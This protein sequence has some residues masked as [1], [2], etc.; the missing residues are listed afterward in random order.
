MKKILSAATASVLLFGAAGYSLAGTKY[1]PVKGPAAASQGCPG[2][3]QDQ[4]DSLNSSQARQDE[5]INGLNSSQ[6]RQ[7]EQINALQADQGRQD[8]QINALEA[9]QAQQDE[10]IRANSARLDQHDNEINALKSRKH[11]AEYNP[12]YVKGLARMIWSGSMDADKVEYGFKADT[13]TGY[14]LAL[15]GGRKIGNFRAEAELA[16]Q[17]TDFATKGLEDMSVRS[18]MF[19]GFYHVPVSTFGILVGPKCDPLSIYGMAGLGAGKADVAFSN[20]AEDSETTFAYKVGAGVAYDIASN[21]AVD[22]GYEYMRLSDIE[23]GNDHGLLRLN[24]MKSSSINAAFR[25][26]F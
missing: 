20:G 16:S 18:M 6:A 2:D 14:G 22:L 11:G 3:C 23:L 24:D 12:W 5:Q 9:G 4:I 25:Y 8:S 10:H 13:D 7:D 17:T 26:S 21:M 19:N 15:A 1:K